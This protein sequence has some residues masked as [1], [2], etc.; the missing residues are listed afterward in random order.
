MGYFKSSRPV[1]SP[2]LASAPQ[3]LTSAS[4]G[5]LIN[6]RGVTI[7]K[8]TATGDKVFRIA[9][10]NAGDFKEIACD[11]SSTATASVRAASTAQTFYGTT[12]DTL[13]F[14]TAGSAGIAKF[15]RLYARTSTSWVVLGRSTGITLA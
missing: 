4:T 2:G 5:T 11:I 10:V 7:I 6:A 13:T 1:L 15:V 14:S 3:S 12:Q 9:K 8:T